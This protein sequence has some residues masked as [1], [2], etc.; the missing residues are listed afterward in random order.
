[1]A[2]SSARG[3][4][5]GLCSERCVSDSDLDGMQCGVVIFDIDCIKGTVARHTA[6]KRHAL[7]SECSQSDYLRDAFETLLTYFRKKSSMKKSSYR[8]N[9]SPTGEFDV[10]AM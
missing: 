5:H 10:C 7:E 4:F 2:D 3:L 1:M 8:H 9:E 6:H